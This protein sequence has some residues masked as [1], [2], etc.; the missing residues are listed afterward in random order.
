MK[1]LKKN[2]IVPQLVYS[3]AMFCIITS[4]I[5]A[6]NF[7]DQD[8]GIILSTLFT[9]ASFS[10]IALTSFI[11]N[12]AMYI[13][14]KQGR[15]AYLIVFGFSLIFLNPLVVQISGVI[16]MVLGLIFQFIRSLK[17]G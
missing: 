14:E 8:E 4:A 1:M 11:V 13:F 3:I 12:A 5:S 2:V 9:K 6:T 15:D 7:L 10:Y 17:K 16:M